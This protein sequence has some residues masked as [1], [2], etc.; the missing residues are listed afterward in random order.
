MG[1]QRLIDL[2]RPGAPASPGTFNQPLEQLQENINWLSEIIRAAEIGSTVYAREVTIEEEARVGT[3]VYFNGETQRYERAL[4][5]MNS[6]FTSGSL[7]AAA[8]SEVWGVVAHK[9]NATL[10]DL[11][12]FGV[13]ELNISEVVDGPVRS[14]TYYLSGRVPGTLTRQKP[15]VSVP[16]LR[17]TS[18]NRVFVNPTFID[19]LENHRHYRFNLLCLP[20]G[21]TSP[22]ADGGQHVITDP[23][24]ACPGWLPANHP[25]FNGFAP[26]GAAFGYNLAMHPSL[27]NSWPPIPLQHVYLEVITQDS[28]TGF[29]GV[30]LGPD[31]LCI[32]DR[33]GIWWMSDC[34]QDVPWPWNITTTAATAGAILLENE[35]FL[36]TES[37]DPPAFFVTEEGECQFS[38]DLTPLTS[39]CPRMQSMQLVLWFTK[40]SFAND[41]TVVTSLVSGDN[42]VR[43]LCSGT[44]VPGQVGDLVIKLDLTTQVENYDEPGY[45]ALKT[46]DG[47]NDRFHAGPVAESLYVAVGSDNVTLNSPLQTPLPGDLFGRQQYH[48]PIEISVS[49]QTSYEIPSTLVRLEGAV[50]ENYPVFYVGLPA[51]EPSSIVS[52]FNVPVDVPTGTKFAYRLRLM[53]H[54]LGTLPQLEVS[55]MI[56]SRPKEGLGVSITQSDVWNPFADLA[57]P[58]NMV[59]SVSLPTG[60]RPALGNLPA[61]V[62][63][64]SEPFAVQAGDIVYMRLR[65]TP[66]SDNDDTYTGDVAII[67]QA[68]VLTSN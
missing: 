54:V 30:P 60:G 4:A 28:S 52:M 37:D 27:L 57:N 17:Y 39:G 65:R 29:E 7:T 42:R 1:F 12:I 21:T 22:P 5:A 55:Y 13:A 33:N 62:E 41:T 25:V 66:G 34:Y 64:E 20:A 59:T 18:S 16:V 63:A 36:L 32:V 19:F 46:F 14:G 49:K 56:A 61:V 24:P 67:Q 3:P 10:A 43:I 53:G 50:N 68:G 26:E 9:H 6:D 8:S 15:P 47:V 51:A 40:M 23:N 45:L 11:L 44:N 48:G 38:S 2:I 35:G 31:G 58:D